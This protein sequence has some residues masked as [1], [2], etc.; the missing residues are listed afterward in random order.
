M[1]VSFVTF[2]EEDGTGHFYQV[3]QCLE[4]D[5]VAQSDSKEGA[6]EAL[7]QTIRQQIRLDFDMGKEPLSDIAPAPYA[8][9]YAST[10]IEQMEIS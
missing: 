1:M 6:V 2:E 7:R 3:A 10:E 4:H 5:V 9:W 8:H